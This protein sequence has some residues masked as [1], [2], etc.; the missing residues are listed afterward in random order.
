MLESVTQIAVLPRKSAASLP[1]RR[2]L[3]WALGGNVVQSRYL[4]SVAR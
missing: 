3:A 1:Q 2:N 4:V